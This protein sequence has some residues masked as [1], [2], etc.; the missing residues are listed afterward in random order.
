LLVKNTIVPQKVSTGCK[1]TCVEY[2]LKKPGESA[3]IAEENTFFLK[4]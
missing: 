2:E 3:P 1:E 4:K